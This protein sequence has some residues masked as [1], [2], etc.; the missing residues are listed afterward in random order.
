MS[1]YWWVMECNVTKNLTKNPLKIQNFTK[2]KKFKNSNF[3]LKI[4]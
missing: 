3:L 2:V 4:R 1:N